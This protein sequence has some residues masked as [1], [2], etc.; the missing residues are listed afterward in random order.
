MANLDKVVRL[1]KE[2]FEQRPFEEV[3]GLWLQNHDVF[4][5]H[6]Q[7]EEIPYFGLHGTNGDNLNAILESKKCRV[8]M[9]TFYD[10]EKSERRLFQLYGM[11]DYVSHYTKNNGQPNGLPGGILVFDLESNGK[12][13]T[14]PW[15]KLFGGT[16]NSTVASD[17]EKTE[18]YFESLDR[19]ENLL[20]R[21]DH[22]FLKNHSENR[23][24]FTERY[25]GTI[26]MD[27]EK[28]GEDLE[29][30][31]MRAY[32]MAVLRHRIRAQHI[33]S[34]SLKLLAKKPE[35]QTSKPSN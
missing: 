11:C 8:N 10:K 25:K 21:S 9:A 29:G 7:S 2:D 19:S 30:L 28:V 17:S 14:L 18:E 3:N 6:I 24:S 34:E 26:L 31:G 32:G 23:Y 1:R 35:S 16:F 20:W 15:E 13:I 22:P 4:L 5:D 33:L 27:K 12:N